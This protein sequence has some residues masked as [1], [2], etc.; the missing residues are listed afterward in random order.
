MT[1]ET[2]SSAIPIPRRPGGRRR[3]F[4]LALAFAVVLVAAAVG[5]RARIDTGG[6]APAHAAAAPAPAPLYVLPE[7]PAARLAAGY[8]AAPERQYADWERTL[9]HARHSEP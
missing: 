2:P 6:P 5:V 9:M 7:Q 8:V 1:L 4:G 3:L